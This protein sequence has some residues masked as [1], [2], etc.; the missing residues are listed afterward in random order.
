MMSAAQATRRCMRVKLS[1]PASFLHFHLMEEA[2]EEEKKKLLFFLL[3]I[4]KNISSIERI[5]YAECQMPS[6]KLYFNSWHW[7]CDNGGKV[8]GAR[9][10]SGMN[11][12]WEAQDIVPG[13]ERMPN[14]GT[15]F[16]FL[17]ESKHFPKG[18]RRKCC[19]CATLS[20]TFSLASW[21]KNQPCCLLAILNK[22]VYKLTL[23][24]LTP[25]WERLRTLNGKTSPTTAGHSCN[26]FCVLSAASTRFIFMV[27]TFA[28][29]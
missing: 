18:H 8:W 1:N 4:N 9:T 17:K 12:S 19:L 3:C 24:F 21:N 6:W 27:L 22:V 20:A 15:W 2:Q 28:L 13:G 5:Q 10:L 11:T 26:T 14:K 25:T 29:M 16:T 7:N 23:K